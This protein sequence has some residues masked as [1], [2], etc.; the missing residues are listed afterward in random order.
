MRC[1]LDL[2][3]LLLRLINV[4]K[5]KEYKQVVWVYESGERNCPQGR[6]QDYTV[7]KITVMKFPPRNIL[8]C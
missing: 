2:I 8:G 6:S 4:L 1:L 5:K 7:P 3:L